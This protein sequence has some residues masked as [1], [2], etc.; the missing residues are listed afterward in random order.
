LADDYAEQGFLFGEGR[1]AIFNWRNS[2]MF[3]TQSILSSLVL[4]VLLSAFSHSGVS[5]SAATRAGA[6]DPA[7]YPSLDDKELGQIRRM[8]KLSRQLPGDWS[9]MSDDFYA[10]AERTQQFQLA[11]MADALAL[12]QHQYTPAYRELYRRAMDDLI[13]KLTLPDIWESWLKSSRGGSSVDDPAAD[14]L[15]AGWLDPVVRDNIMLKGYLLQC[16]SL[17]EMLYRDGKYNRSDAFTFRYVAGTWGN[18]PVVF[19]YS[20]PD[21][22]R[23][24]HQEYVDSNYEGVMCEPNRIFPACQ[25]P[26]ILGLL[27]FDQSHGTAYAADVMPRFAA[28]W[29]DRHYTD[30][31]T[32]QNVWFIYAKQRT[33]AG[34]GSPQLDGWA[35]AWMHAWDPDL[36]QTIYPGQRDRYVGQYLSGAYA[37]HVPPENKGMLS[38]G[39]GQIAFMAAENGD[40]KTRGE[41]L[42]YA[43]RNFHPKW[44]DGTYYYPRNDD[45]QRDSQGNSHGVD[46]WSGNALLAL[47]RLDAG[48]GFQR[49]YH[50]PWGKEQLEAPQITDVDY[51]LVNV[52]QAFYDEQKKALILALKPGP[53]ATRQTT[54]VIRNLDPNSVYTLVRD[55]HSLG[56]ISRTGSSSE[57]GA[58][59]RPDGGLAI[60]TDLTHPHSFVLV[61]N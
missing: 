10:V 19:R 23:I 5:A 14:D 50:S 25:Q 26:A 18:G 29:V 8:V 7:D 27:S 22:A 52:S 53:M 37:E 24:V 2:G 6:I 20:L 44:D 46:S 33:S 55:G 32:K 49:L 13:Q 1:I 31:V 30:P 21:I 42:D 58:T 35:G 39:F 11:Y 48:G 40:Q 4:G 47:T 59:W 9:G 43:E 15:T 51:L 57:S 61:A 56:S 17:Y 38:F 12:V 3:H 60:A 41:M 16:G 54:F 28:A 45:Y 36:M 34:P